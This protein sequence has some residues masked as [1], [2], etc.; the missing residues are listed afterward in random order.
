MAIARLSGISGMHQTQSDAMA[1]ADLRCSVMRISVSALDQLHLI[2]APSS[3]ELEG[4]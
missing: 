3:L 1:I 2:D 4:R